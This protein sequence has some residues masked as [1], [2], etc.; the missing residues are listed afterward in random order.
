M[1]E[2][3][4]QMADEPS[5]FE[6]YE[7]WRRKTLPQSVNDAAWRHD[8][9]R[10][11]LMRLE[12][13]LVDRFPPASPAAVE[14]Q[15]EILS[16]LR[17]LE[18]QKVLGYAKKRV[19]S[20]GDGGYVQTDD[21][22]GVSHAFSFGVCDDDAWD[23]AI[24]QAGVAVEQ[25]DGTVEGAPS[26]HPLLRFHRKM[27]GVESGPETETLPDLVARHSK[28]DGPDLLLKMDIEGCE[29]DVFDRA[30]AETLA[31][32]TQILCE[33]HEMSRLVAPDFRARARRVFEK[34]HKHFA[35]THVHANNCAPFSL[36]ANIPI[37][38]V[39]E[40]TLANR[41]RYQFERSDEIFPTPLDAPC[42]PDKLDYFLGAF[43]F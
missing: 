5:F 34:L 18:P 16:I 24:A 30:S 41:A 26:S 10:A 20:A 3:G 8:E 29:W 27:I 7:S 39:L 4:I 28:S 35:V 14:R 21:L 11:R 31:K 42:S 15:D 1:A 37:P 17:L 38:D 36:V 19:G 23:L 12:E 13:L 43:R 25:F 22:A 40:I 32:H 33:F 9:L 2:G 6:K